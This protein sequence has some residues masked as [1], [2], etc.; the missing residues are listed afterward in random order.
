MGYLAGY[1]WINFIIGTRAFLHGQNPYLAGHGFNMVFEPF[2]TYI[3]LS[4]FAV[5][6]FWVGRAA[7]AL[8]AMTVYYL[9][10]I[11]MGGKLWQ[12][13]LFMFS[14]P[15]LGYLYSGNIDWMVTAGFWMPPQIGLFFVLMKPQIGLGI[16]CFWAWMAWNKG[17]LREITRIFAP[18]T[19]AYGISFLIYD[20]WPKYLI[21][22]PH[23]PFNTAIFPFGT[24][25]GIILILSS[26]KKKEQNL[27]GIAS[28]FFAPYM[29]VFNLSGML[30]CLFT[31]PKLFIL[32]WVLLWILI[33]AK[34]FG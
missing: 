10:A 34:N 24:V 29:N 31:R 15:V 13:L 20:F 12:V 25:F 8:V 33:I 22:M 14:G 17:G 7:I 9:N 2:W 32:T 18:V 19:I 11:K 28:P 3:L 27:S 1:D 6:P 21:G 23:N 26:F 4:P 16:A 30:L 5:M